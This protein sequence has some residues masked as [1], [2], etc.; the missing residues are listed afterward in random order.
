MIVDFD[1]AGVAQAAEILRRGGLVAFP[2]E[3]VYGLGARAD[4]AEAVHRIYEAKGRPSTNPSII[5]TRDAKSAFELADRVPRVA[6]TLAERLWPGPLTLVLPVR[7][8]AVA[9]EALAHG[10]T[11]ALR[12]P[13]HPAALALLEAVAL[14]IAAPSANLSSGVSPTTA[15]HVQNGL[16]SRVE[17]VL[18]GGPTGFGIESTIVDL[19]GDQPVLLRRGSIS[20]ERLASLGVVAIDAADAVTLEHERARAPGGFARHY[21]PHASLLLVPR[22]ALAERVATEM[23][24]GAV[25]GVIALGEAPE[26]FGSLSEVRIE[27]LPDEAVGFARELYAALHRLDDARCEVIL[28][29]LVPGDPT[30]AAVRDRLTRASRSPT[31]G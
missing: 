6:E 17:L 28:V 26:A 22:S 1:A 5:H 20:L 25:V 19:S 29:E 8:G 9:A 13:A 18:D 31:A 15:L 14:P 30:W 16:G 2:T 23:E 21:A 10:T 4:S 11:I 7:R 24:R 3:T 27:E 12:V